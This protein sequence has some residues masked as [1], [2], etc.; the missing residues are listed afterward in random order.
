MMQMAGSS[1]NNQES[2][3]LSVE[4]IGYKPTNLR[5]AKNAGGIDMTESEVSANESDKHMNE[6]IEV[7]DR[8]KTSDAVVIKSL[9][10]SVGGLT[11]VKSSR[12]TSKITKMDAIT[13][14]SLDISV[15]GLKGVSKIVET[16]I[17][18]AKSSDISVGGL[19]NV[20]SLGGATKSA[21]TITK[22]WEMATISG[23]RISMITNLNNPV[24]ALPPFTSPQLGTS[25][26]MPMLASF[27]AP[28]HGLG[29]LSSLGHTLRTISRP[30]VLPQ[31]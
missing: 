2:L 19:K 30:Q 7:E 29:F 8:V 27:V 10:V 16:D 15:G 28:R 13:A 23:T 5:N 6:S 3:L 21:M 18:I 4:Y 25:I 11:G 14:K 9:N 17:V 1:P 12:D 31:G 20:G 26:S 24:M 22:R